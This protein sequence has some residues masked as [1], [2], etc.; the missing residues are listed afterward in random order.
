[1]TKTNKEKESKLPMMMTNKMTMPNPIRMRIFMFFQYICLRTPEAPFL[2]WTAPCSRS[3]ML[4]RPCKEKLAP[5]LVPSG[6]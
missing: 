4:I 2:N 5:V 1:M 6:I 3:A